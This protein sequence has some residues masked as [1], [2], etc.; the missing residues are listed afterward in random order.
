M[1]LD[2]VNDLLSGSGG[3]P[4]GIKGSESFANIGDTVVMVVQGGKKVQKRAYGTGDPM[5]FAD[6][7]PMMQAAIYGTVDGEERTLY[8]NGNMSAAI[9]DAV[10]AAGASSIAEGGTLKVRF[11]SEKDTGKGN[12]L[13]EFKAKYEPPVAT[14]SVDDF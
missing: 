9:K 6:G 2:D 8:C 11:D 5:F 4:P 3:L 13:K 1:S 7:N 14:V 12:P 10:A